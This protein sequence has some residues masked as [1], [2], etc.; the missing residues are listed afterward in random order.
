[1]SHAGYQHVSHSV[2]LFGLSELDLRR[3]V[4]ECHD[5]TC[6]VVEQQLLLHYLNRLLR[7]TFL[8]QRDVNYVVLLKNS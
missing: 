6:Y 2:L 3:D 4:S 8:V 5:L 1:M 7:F